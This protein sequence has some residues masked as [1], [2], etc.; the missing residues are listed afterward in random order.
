MGKTALVP[1][2]HSMETNTA[3]APIVT[4]TRSPHD[5]LSTVQIAALLK[6]NL[7]LTR[8]QVSVAA[9]NS[10][11]YVTITVRD[12]AVDLAAVR[13]F[14]AT[15][16]TW[17]MDQADYCEGQSVH[18]RTT[19]DVDAAHAAPFLAEIIQAVERSQDRTIEPLSKGAALWNIDGE[20]W[21]MRGHERGTY[22][23][24]HDAKTLA[25]WAIEALALHLARLA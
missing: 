21:V 15:L 6:S 9:P 23:R 3:T 4:A 8:R 2:Y 19:K 7:G 10:R 11:T 18:V 20:M 13:A 12:A 24:A 22:I 5:H 16:H 14:A 17:T 25:F 1:Y